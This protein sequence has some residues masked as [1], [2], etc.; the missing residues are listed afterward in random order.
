MRGG[1]GAVAVVPVLVAGAAGLLG[2]VAAG[3]G[4][5]MGVTWMPVTAPLMALFFFALMVCRAARVALRFSAAA[6][7][8]S[9]VCVARVFGG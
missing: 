5:A 7:F 2:A 6:I 9:A 4:E 3:C 1:V 8:A